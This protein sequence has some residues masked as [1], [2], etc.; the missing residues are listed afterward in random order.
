MSENEELHL[1]LESC[2]AR[3][4]VLGRMT[5]ARAKT[6]S[7]MFWVAAAY[8]LAGAGLFQFFGNAT[9]GYVDTASLFW[10]WISQWIDPRA[11]TEHGWLILGLSVWILS[12]NWRTGLKAEGPELNAESTEVDIE[13]LE[14]GAE[15]LEMGGPRCVQGGSAAVTPL[16][17]VVLALALHALGFVAQQTRISIVAFLL[18]TWGVLAIANRRW[19]RA[20]AFPLGFMVFAIPLNVLDSIGFWLRLGV[21]DVVTALAH[22]VGLEVVR[23]GTQLFAPDGRFQYDVAA[24]CSGVRSL[25]ALAALSLLIGY[26]NFRSTWRRALMLLLCF[27]LTYLGNVARVGLIIVAAQSGGPRWGALVHD[28]MGYGIFVIVLGGVLGAAALVRKFWP[29]TEKDFGVAGRARRP[30]EPQMTHALTARRGRLALPAYLFPGSILLLTIS[31]MFFLAHL[32]S[33]IGHGAAGVRLSADGANPVELPAF[34]GTEWIGRR[35]DV[36]PVER[37]ILPADTGF[38]RRTYVSLQDKSHSVFVSIV[39]SGRDRTSIHR[40]ELCLVGQGWNI[41]DAAVHAFTWRDR[42][43][44]PVQATILHTT[45]VAPVSNRKIQALVA[46]W[47]V[48]AD[49]VVAT[50][51]QRFLHDAWNRVRHGRVDRWAYVLVQADSLDGETAALARMQ[52]V[53][54]ETLPVF[55]VAEQR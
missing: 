48:S 13:G 23:S 16:L 22:G 29:E 42:T 51:W 46:Y 33:S 1:G 50:H 25:M 7:R 4:R 32:S 30:A 43:K 35:T 49:V 9:R 36:S 12:R 47:F 21:I 45:L 39:L 27:P 3:E 37:E 18:F 28:L 52:A 20:A 41:A 40:P 34:V 11:E 54:D 26:L 8:A 19:A 44:A 5:P 55:Q 10:W 31:E 15:G 17:A 38:S 14:L 6:Q 24:A 53:L 2:A